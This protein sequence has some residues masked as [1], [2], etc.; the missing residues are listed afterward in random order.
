VRVTE[1]VDV[2]SGDLVAVSLPPGEHWVWLLEDLW[3]AGAGLLPLDI[4]LTGAES[5]RLL[6]LARPSVL[7]DPD[8]IHIRQDSAPVAQRTGLVLATSGTSA[9]PR[10]VELSR[11]ALTAAA[12]TSSRALGAD[13]GERWIACLTPAHAGGIMVL[14]RGLLSGAPVRVLDQF[15]T[16][17]IEAPEGESVF[18][19]VVPQ[20]VGWLTEE[21]GRLDGVT[22]L[23][24]GGARRAAEPAAPP[25]PPP[26][27][28]LGARVVQ[29]YGLTET[30]GGIV[31]DGRPLP[32]T[33]VRIGEGGGI[34][35][36]GPT[37][38]S[39]YR[40]DPQATHE[41]FTADGWMRTGD[42]GSFEGGVL[43]VLG[44]SDDRI[45]TGAET[46]WPEEVESVLRDHPKVADCAAAGVPDPEWG[47]QVAVWI[48]PTSLDGPPALEELQLHCEGRL[49]RFKF[50]RMLKLVS[51]IP[52]TATGKIRRSALR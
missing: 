28:A 41:V 12:H 9:A 29:S 33:E 24:G 1:R 50:P 22:L 20:M 31:H 2:G 14:L 36:R 18:A 39:G 45:R 32:G 35:V 11:E 48:V 43:E 40:G 34:E 17:E 38:M 16:S 37:L 6:D 15:R 21:G 52:R 10:L 27:T 3:T 51:Q 42:L 25:P 19:S 26:P 23:V 49:A 8:G 5:A 7:V 44:R 47:Q 13:G 46:V 4:R 30:C